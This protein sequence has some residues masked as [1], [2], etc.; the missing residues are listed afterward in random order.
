MLRALLINNCD[1]SAFK[2][3]HL[4]INDA[5]HI[6]LLKLCMKNTNEYYLEHALR[7]NIFGGHIINSPAFIEDILL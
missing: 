2:Y 4:Y 1:V 6:D 7:E 5:N 3:T